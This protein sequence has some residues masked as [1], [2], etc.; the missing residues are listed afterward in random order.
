M[1]HQA[2]RAGLCALGVV[3]WVGVEWGFHHHSGR[4]ALFLRNHVAVPTCSEIQGIRASGIYT[5]LTFPK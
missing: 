2:C 1:F 4:Y 5:L 3:W